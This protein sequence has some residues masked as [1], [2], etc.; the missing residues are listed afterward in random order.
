MPSS[1]RKSMYAKTGFGWIWF[2]LLFKTEHQLENTRCFWLGTCQIWFCWVCC[3]ARSREQRRCCTVINVLNVRIFWD[4]VPCNSEERITS[5]FKVE[6]QPI[7]KPAKCRFIYGL[8]DSTAQRMAKL[9]TTAVRTANCTKSNVLYGSPSINCAKLNQKR[10][11]LEVCTQFC[12]KGIRQFIKH[13]FALGINAN[14]Y[15]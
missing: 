3:I 11:K 4:I 9:I 8:H 7:K 2:S 15:V 6:N 12:V 10:L 5:I 1:S 13:N 14:L